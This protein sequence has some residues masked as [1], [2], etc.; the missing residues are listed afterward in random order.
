MWN[1]CPTE[2]RL[3]RISSE[4][5]DDCRLI[6]DVEN[7][8][9]NNYYEAEGIIPM[10]NLI[11]SFRNAS[12]DLFLSTPNVQPVPYRNDQ[13]SSEF[14]LHGNIQHEVAAVNSPEHSTVSEEIVLHS[15]PYSISGTIFLHYNAE[16]FL[17]RIVLTINPV[18]SRKRPARI[19]ESLGGMRSKKGRSSH[20]AGAGP[21]DGAGAAGGGAGAASRLTHTSPLEPAPPGVGAHA[22]T[23]TDVPSNTPSIVGVFHASLSRIPGRSIRAHRA[24]RDAGG[25]GSGTL[26]RRMEPPMPAVEAL[27]NYTGVTP[28]TPITPITPFLGESSASPFL[29]PSTGLPCVKLVGY[30]FTEKTVMV[31]GV[32][33]RRVVLAE[34]PRTEDSRR[35]DVAAGVRVPYDSSDVAVYLLRKEF[36]SVLHLTC[37]SVVIEGK[38]CMIVLSADANSKY[39]LAVRDPDLQLVKYR[40]RVTEEHAMDGPSVLLRLDVA[41][42][43]E[44]FVFTISLAHF[45]GG[46]RLLWKGGCGGVWAGHMSERST[47]NQQPVVIKRYFNASGFRDRQGVDP[48]MLGSLQSNFALGQLFPFQRRVCVRENLTSCDLAEGFAQNEKTGGKENPMCEVELMAHIARVIPNHA[49]FFSTLRDFGVS[50]NDLYVLTTE[51]DGPSLFHIKDARAKA[52]LP[53]QFSE[54]ISKKIIRRLLQ[55]L[56]VLHVQRIA[57]WD[58]KIENTSFRI[59]PELSGSAER[60]LLFKKL[61][62]SPEAMSKD[63]LRESDLSMLDAMLIDF[64]QAVWDLPQDVRAVAIAQNKIESDAMNVVSEGFSAGVGQYY[65]SSPGMKTVAPSTA[66]PTQMS[67]LS[68]G[69]W[70]REMT[71]GR[72]PPGNAHSMA[73][74]HSDFLRD[75]RQ[76][77]A[78]RGPGHTDPALPPRHFQ[79]EKIDMWQVGVMLFGLLTDRALFT[80]VT[81]EKYFTDVRSE[82]HWQRVNIDQRMAMVGVSVTEECKDFL[83]QL[84]QVEP[85]VRMSVETAL[86]HP[87]LQ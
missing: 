5:A 80:E 66:D 54:G 12:P 17:N 24:A 62:A 20:A 43:E 16:F 67:A 32:T 69:L 75:E 36:F 28:I 40:F 11:Q 86:Q 8:F 14:W 65:G 61:R 26:K 21:G 2:E 47:S 4:C 29:N 56:Q 49:D 84:L 23:E 78:N 70:F 68:A 19:Q 38:E 71:A 72:S 53:L 3:H 64:G 18:L 51:L 6:I 35:L 7:P 55:A 9:G 79:P 50:A 46:G 73:P 15:V 30:E 82:P 87:W 45:E 41:R 59:K 37:L 33:H 58:I 25:A 74:E 31:D 27:T 48:A 39:C 1:D 60:P 10:F 57:H 34:V 76:A 81:R 42:N 22:G 63:P 85:S 13:Y 44:H 77:R 52:G 83:L